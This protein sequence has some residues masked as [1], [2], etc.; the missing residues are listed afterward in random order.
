MDKKTERNLLEITGKGEDNNGKFYSV[1]LLDQSK[2]NA[3]GR[4]YNGD[5]AH[6][7]RGI[8]RMPRLFCEVDPYHDYRFQFPV[9]D[10]R[11]VS[12]PCTVDMKNVC[13]SI[14]NIRHDKMNQR[15]SAELRPWGPQA[16][17]VRDLLDGVNQNVTFGMRALATPDGKIDKVITWD[18]LPE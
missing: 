3:N 1:V 15:V 8:K 13:A 10:D 18:L 6:L 2:I 9:T 12:G 4:Q 16:S 5:L 7:V 11:S 14:E 17:M